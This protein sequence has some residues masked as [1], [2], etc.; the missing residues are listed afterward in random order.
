[1]WPYSKVLTLIVVG[2]VVVFCLPSIAAKKSEYAISSYAKYVQ[3]PGANPMGADT[4]STCH[5][6]IA[7]DFGTRFMPSK[8]WNASSATALAACTCR[9]AGTFPR[10]SPFATVPPRTLTVYA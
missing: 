2:L 4:C 7:K 6:D 9:A 1:M 5:A 10:S 3:I 8:A